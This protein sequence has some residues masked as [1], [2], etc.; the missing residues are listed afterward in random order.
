MERPR[1]DAAKYDSSTLYSPIPA[2]LHFYWSV[3]LFLTP[4]KGIAEVN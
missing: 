2:P 3:W 1:V 4:S